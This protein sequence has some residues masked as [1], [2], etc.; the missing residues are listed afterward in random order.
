MCAMPVAKTVGIAEELP[1]LPRPVLARSTCPT[2]SQFG[3]M[4][5]L[6]GIRAHS[7]VRTGEKIFRG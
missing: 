7:R 1:E 5:Q 4:C 3:V 6:S 2:G